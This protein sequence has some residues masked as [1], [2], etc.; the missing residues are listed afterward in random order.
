MP[1]VPIIFGVES[2]ATKIKEQ[3]HEVDI[4]KLSE[5]HFELNH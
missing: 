3:N 5:T 1:K 4:I 2:L